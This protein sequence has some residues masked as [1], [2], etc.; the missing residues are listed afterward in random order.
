[1]K[2]T[3]REQ[4]RSNNNRKKRITVWEL[5]GSSTKNKSKRYNIMTEFVTKDIREHVIYNFRY[6]QIVALLWMRKLHNNKR[7]ER[8]EQKNVL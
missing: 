6:Q 2:K 8:T 1:M 5:F 7:R 4:L 3:F